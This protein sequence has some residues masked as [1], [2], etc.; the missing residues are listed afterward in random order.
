M[1]KGTSRKPRTAHQVTIFC[2]KH[3]SI[4]QVLKA[5]RVYGMSVRLNAFTYPQVANI[6]RA[7]SKWRH[8]MYNHWKPPGVSTT[9]ENV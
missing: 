9:H 3:G 4:T 6:N 2:R 5:W 7:F 1:Y 8:A